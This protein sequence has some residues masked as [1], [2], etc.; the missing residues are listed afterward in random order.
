MNS[1]NDFSMIFRNDAENDFYT[2]PIVK[3]DKNNL[4]V[5]VTWVVVCCYE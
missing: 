4:E 1:G 3:F 5:L 2:V